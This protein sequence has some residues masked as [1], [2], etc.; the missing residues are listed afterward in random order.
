ME[1]KVRD[2]DVTY[3]VKEQ[4]LFCNCSGFGFDSTNVMIRWVQIPYW[5]IVLPLT[6]FSAWLLLSKL[7]PRA[8]KV[9]T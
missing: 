5:S 7:R 6:L 3:P 1:L 4:M 2:M 8:A 9:L